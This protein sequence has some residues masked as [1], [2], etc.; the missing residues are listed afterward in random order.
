MQV[1]NEFEH[2]SGKDRQILSKV[3]DHIKEIQ[4]THYIFGNTL[5]EFFQNSVYRNAVAFAVSQIGELLNLTTCDIQDKR[6]ISALRCKIVHHYGK[7]DIE[8]LWNVSHADILQLKND[9]EGIYNET[10]K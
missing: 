1:T 7:I 10:T 5:A 3:L 9:V 8:Q 2:I 6:A 4:D